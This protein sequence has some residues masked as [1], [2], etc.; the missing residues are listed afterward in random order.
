MFIPPGLVQKVVERFEADPLERLRLV[1]IVSCDFVQ[2][3]GS[4]ADDLQLSIHEITPSDTKEHEIGVFWA[5]PSRPFRASE[6]ELKPSS[7]G[8]APG[9]FISRFQREE[10]SRSAQCGRDVRPPIIRLFPPLRLSAY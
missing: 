3:R 2:F 9:Y 6:Q 8:V 5:K 7:R 10:L 1:R 4:C